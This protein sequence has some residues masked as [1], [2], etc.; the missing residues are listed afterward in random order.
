MI[1]KLTIVLFL[2]AFSFFCTHA[3]NTF[4]KSF[5]TDGYSS[6]QSVLQ[7]N[8]GFVVAGV[9]TNFTED[10]THVFL[11]RTDTTGDTLW[12][13]TFKLKKIFYITFNNSLQQMADGGFILTG[14]SRNSN[15]LDSLVL[16]KTD[17]MGNVLWTKLIGELNTELAG[18]SI[19]PTLD[20]GFIVAGQFYKMPGALYILLMKLDSTGSTIWTKAITVDYDGEGT[21][22]RQ[23][24]DGG[25]IITGQAGW[26][27]FLVKTNGVG[28]VTWSKL[29]PTGAPYDVAYS[30][31]E[32]SGGYVVCGTNSIDSTGASRILLMKTNTDGDTLWTHN[33]FGAS[34]FVISSAGTDLVHTSDGGFAISGFVTQQDDG[35]NYS[36]LLKTDSA[37]VLQWSRTFGA[38]PGTNI[39][40]HSLEQTSDGGYIITGNTN[41]ISL[42]KT[43][44]LGRSSCTDSALIIISTPTTILNAFGNVYDSIISC[45]ASYFIVE[46]SKGMASI[47]CSQIG[48]EEADMSAP[49]F[50]LYPNPAHHS[51]SIFLNDWETNHREIITISDIAGKHVYFTRINFQ[52]GEKKLTFDLNLKSGLYFVKLSNNEKTSVQKLVIE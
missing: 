5:K 13:R 28:N 24:S 2:S 34:S 22:V 25:Y 17:S 4:Y 43:D 40:C 10:T 12:T 23:T 6:G 47:D 32:A 51:I 30:V 18:E 27:I 42:I 20:G 35:A 52:Q 39:G 38:T 33:Y 7:I 44:S 16:L 21:C 31:L 15:Q 14:W 11:L 29:Y 9:S 3:Q 49:S 36:C 26:R 1:N 46:T 8:G 37:G 50:I 48:I 19:H 41:D 45:G